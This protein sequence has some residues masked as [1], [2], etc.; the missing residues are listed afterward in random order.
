VA[1][2]RSITAQA[3][4]LPHAARAPTPV[5]GV[6]FF[7][8]V[9]LKDFEKLLY[10]FIPLFL[11]EYFFTSGA[12]WFLAEIAKDMAGTQSKVSAFLKQSGIT[13]MVAMAYLS[14]IKSWLYLATKIAVGVWLFFAARKFNSNSFIW[15]IFGGVTGVLAIAVFYLVLIYE[16]EATIGA[17]S[18][19]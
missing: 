2:E 6:M 11:I 7:W 5:V 19:T 10:W 9:V 8:R 15:A 17:P 13:P 1:R 16:R 18:K 14:A 4:G 12:S 3:T